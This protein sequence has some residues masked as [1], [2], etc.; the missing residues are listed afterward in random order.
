MVVAANVDRMTAF[1]FL[2]ENGERLVS[3]LRL[4][5]GKWRRD[6]SLICSKAPGQR[7]LSAQDRDTVA[8][9]TVESA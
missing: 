5:V 9:V 2:A 1:F 8:R 7:R 4:K 3:R 6:W